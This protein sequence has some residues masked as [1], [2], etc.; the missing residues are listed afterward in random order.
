MA[1]DLSWDGLSISRN[2]WEIVLNEVI[3][4]WDDRSHIQHNVHIGLEPKLLTVMMERF[5]TCG[6]I[7]FVNGPLETI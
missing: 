6:V 3:N 5:R 7:K 4:D 1:F 2:G